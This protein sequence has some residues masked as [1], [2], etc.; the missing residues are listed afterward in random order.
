MALKAMNWGEGLS[1]LLPVA[2]SRFRGRRV[3]PFSGEGE[4][5]KGRK[6]LRRPKGEKCQQESIPEEEP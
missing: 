2:S 1:I 4:L 6:T 5:G 3:R